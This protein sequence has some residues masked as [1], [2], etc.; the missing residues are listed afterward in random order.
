MRAQLRRLHSP[1]VQDLKTFS[2][3][4]VDAFGFLLQI[5]VG[6]EEQQGED[7]F[8]VVVC[9]PDWLKRNFKTSDI[10][11]GQGR[12]LVFEYNYERLRSFIERYCEK[13]V[14]DTW[15]DIATKLSRIGRWE[16]EG[17]QPY[18]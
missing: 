9:T 2:P 10:I 1:D 14:A 5:M 13:C 3:L 6:P 18:K 16:F 15:Q 17:Y 4:P 11:L 8:D 12:I 7:S